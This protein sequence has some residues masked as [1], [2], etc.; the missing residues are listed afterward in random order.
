[1]EIP[2]I[3]IRTSD[4]NNEKDYFYNNLIRLN[5]YKSTF[6]VLF[7]FQFTLDPYTSIIHSNSDTKLDDIKFLKHYKGPL[8]HLNRL[9]CP[10]CG[11]QKPQHPKKKINVL[12]FRHSKSFCPLMQRMCC[13]LLCVQTLPSA[14][15]ASG[16][17]GLFKVTVRKKMCRTACY[18]F[19]I[20]A[21]LH[22]YKQETFRYRLD[23]TLEPLFWVGGVVVVLV[24][25]YISA[26]Q[27]R[28]GWGWDGVM[29]R[30]S[31]FC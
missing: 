16:E 2:N 15:Q 31:P 7:K 13:N 28:G 30:C 14:N 25:G 10:L 5:F 3:S 21:F 11:Y 18:A 17:R 24:V 27:L 4:V 6:M 1:M 8:H 22:D 12:L 23:Q 20:A 9:P 29:C 19:F 26:I